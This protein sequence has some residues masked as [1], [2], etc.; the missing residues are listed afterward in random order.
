M[1]A[2]GQS[3]LL[4]RR[5]IEA[6]THFVT[7]TDGGWDTHQNNFRSLKERKLPV[8]DRGYAAL[9]E[10]LH[11]RGLLDNTLVVWFG[12][13]G[14]TPKINPSAGRDHWA[15]AGVACMGG[16][17][18]KMGQVVGATNKLG[19]FVIDNPVT[20]QDPAATIY[21][22]LGRPL[23]PRFQTQDRRPLE[24]VPEGKPVQ[25]FV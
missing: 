8:L 7:V 17:G 13:F 2:F 19:E 11:E 23:N 5:L 20:P 15:S 6:G 22:T 16:G 1:T 10:D 18:V 4:A 24:L 9:L 14:R 25:Q 3:C 12:D 21:H